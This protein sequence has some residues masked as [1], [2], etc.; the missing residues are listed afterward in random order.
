M[1]DLYNTIHMVMLTL[2]YTCTFSPLSYFQSGYRGHAPVFAANKHCT[3]IIIESTSMT[4][5]QAGIGCKNTIYHCFHVILYNSYNKIPRRSSLK[6]QREIEY[7]SK[8]IFQIEYYSKQ[9]FQ[10]FQTHIFV[11]RRSH[12]TT[13]H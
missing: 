2:S 5:G 6:F 9:I 8:Q 10:I 3:C 12:T 4:Q 1:I 11:F 13:T 7:Y